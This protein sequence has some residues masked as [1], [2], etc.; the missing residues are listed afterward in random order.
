MLPMATHEGFSKNTDNTVLLVNNS[1]FSGFMLLR[2]DI[3]IPIARD[4]SSHISGSAQTAVVTWSH[5]SLMYM[6]TGSEYHFD[7]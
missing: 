1:F 3:L 4:A 5:G 2:H 6:D 7:K